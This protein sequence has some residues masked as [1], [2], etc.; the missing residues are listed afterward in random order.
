M[1]REQSVTAILVSYNSA[2]VIGEALAPLL[3]R[4]EIA[5]IMVMDNCS[6][7][8]TCDLI[9]S[10]FPSVLLTEN[11]RN[12]GF[13]RGNNIALKKIITPYALLVN[14]DAVLQEGALEKLLDAAETYPDAAI[15]A[16]ALYNEQGEL[17]VSFKSDVWQREKRSSGAPKNNAEGDICAEY[18]SG[19][20]W[21]LNMRLMRQVGFFDPNIFLYYEDDDLCLRARRAGCG[22]VYVP[23]ARVTHLM[24]ASSGEIKIES[25]FFRQRHMAWSRLYIEEKYRGN[26]AAGALAARQ[27]IEYSLKAAFYFFLMNARRTARYRGR[28][29]GIFDY[30]EKLPLK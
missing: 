28:L 24:G 11:P 9:R 22:L 26:K 7:D 10:E 3:K 14:P 20:V 16:P 8:R 15:L 29:Q 27:N 30:Q 21:L 13:G 18:L 19:A 2:D 4:P 17:H 12:E 25:E 6:T 5:A 23:A 1:L